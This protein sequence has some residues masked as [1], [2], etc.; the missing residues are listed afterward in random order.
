MCAIAGIVDMNGRPV[1]VQAIKRMTDVQAH[2]GP[3]GEGMYVHK[4]I[5]LGHRRLSIIDLSE[6]G[7]QPMFSRNGRYVL[8]FNGEIYNYLELKRA[9]GKWPWKSSSA[10][11]VLLAAYEKWGPECV[12]KF[13][14]I[15]AFA[16]WDTKKKELFCAR[17]H[18]GVKPF[19]YSFKNGKFVFASEIKGVRAA[20]VHATP[21]EQYMYDFLVHGYYHHRPAE[22]FFEGI[23][24]LPQGHTLTV[25]KKG[26]TVAPFW[27]LA[28]AANKQAALLKGVT[29]REV[30]KKFLQTFEDAIKLQLRS[31]VP[32]GLQL[33]GGFDSSAVTGMVHRVLGGQK[34]MRLFSFVYGSYEDKE[35]SYMRSLARGLGWKLEITHVLPKDMQGLMEQAVWHAEEPFPGLPTFGQFLLAEKCRKEGI[36]VILG[37]QGGDEI[38]AG[39]EYYLGAYY[40]DCLRERGAETALS[41]L[42]AYGRR[43]GLTEKEQLAFFARA[44]GSY[45][46]GGT[47]ADGT[48]F[49]TPS[50]LSPAFAARAE[51]PRPH[52][53]EPFDSALSNM[54]Y[55]DIVATKLPR[56]LQAADRSAMAYGIEHRVPLLDHRLVA[57]GLALPTYFKI[58]GGVQ[59]YYM[60]QA[61]KGLVPERV[62]NAPKRPVPSPQREWFKK[63]LQPWVHSILSS[64][65]F[66]SRPYFNQ[67]EV[68]KEYGRYCNTSGVPANSFHIW[69][70][71]FFEMWLRKY[72][73]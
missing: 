9:I 51:V 67:K 60:R 5:G 63:E 10:S 22:T 30:E 62:L 70:W 34:N 52:F 2:R 38:G 53:V 41:E 58:R 20:G 33:S 56:I 43:H 21:N 32:V 14:G 47:S 8:T 61:M 59:R 24:Q 36:P 57:L 49:V 4:N 23:A 44:I 73:D 17:D 71:I 42:A 6:A 7:K 48:S 40:V 28:L 37:G 46:Y 3:D 13:N 26:I 16:I 50:A 11:E 31:D 15:F 27:D 25:S 45:M 55:R 39:Y 35:V 64:K 12:K 66:K 65:S 69:Q 54:Q 68:L 1:S 72:F 19:F 29:D 18:V